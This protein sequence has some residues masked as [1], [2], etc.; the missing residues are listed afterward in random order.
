MSV[1]KYMCCKN[2]FILN[3]EFLFVIFFPGDV[4]IFMQ[5]SEDNTGVA[6]SL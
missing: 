2:I 1:I 4:G 5:V 6:R 3:F